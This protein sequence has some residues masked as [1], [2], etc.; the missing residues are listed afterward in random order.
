MSINFLAL[1]GKR[2]MSYVILHY[3]HSIKTNSLVLIK[4]GIINPL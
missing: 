2:T 4:L 3:Y 1:F